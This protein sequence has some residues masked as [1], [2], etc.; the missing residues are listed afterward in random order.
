MSNNNDNDGPSGYVRDTQGTTCDIFYGAYPPTQFQNGEN[1]DPNTRTDLSVNHFN[2][3]NGTDIGREKE[4]RP[5]ESAGGTKAVSS[6]VNN[7]ASDGED[8]G[9][10]PD[11]TQMKRWPQYPKL[12]KKHP[13]LVLKV[14][15]CVDDCNATSEPQADNKD[16]VKGNKW[17]KLF[18]VCYGGNRGLL[19]P[20]LAKPANASRLKVCIAE[21]WKHCVK[22]RENEDVFVDVDTEVIEIGCRQQDEYN[23]CVNDKKISSAK[24]KERTAQQQKEMLAYERQL[25]AIPPGAKGRQGAGRSDHSTNLGLGKPATYA[26]ANASTINLD[27]SDDENVRTPKRPRQRSKSPTTS[28]S[29]STL[30]SN[31]NAQAA[32]ALSNLDSTLYRLV[33]R[34]PNSSKKSSSILRNLNKKK[35][36]VGF[37]G[38]VR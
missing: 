7:D 23:K 1:E 12:I 6:T 10:I 8:E 32:N 17:A 16:N 37:E 20:Y 22:A 4:V 25:G 3:V 9:G 11:F 27:D 35:E 2:E 30:T 34:L 24:S 38:R 18:D 14:L 33:D 21:V 28:A 31:S 29:R 19:S 26:Y 13:E 15:K 36:S 5:A